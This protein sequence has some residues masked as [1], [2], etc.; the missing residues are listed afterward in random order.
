MSRQ[1]D[2]AGRTGPEYLPSN[3]GRLTTARAKYKFSV[4]GGAVSTITP[5][6]N[7][8]LPSGA[9]CVGAIINSTAAVT[10]NG[11]ATVAIGLSAGGD[12]D[13][14]LSATGKASYSLNALL[15]SDVTFAAPIKLTANAYITVVVGTAA[16]TAGEIEI[17]VFYYKALV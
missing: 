8:L 15:A 9:V 10:S 13:A 7:E 14:F 1:K 17:V 12:A 3:W 5:V 4:D 2:Y 6:N 16:L 11:S